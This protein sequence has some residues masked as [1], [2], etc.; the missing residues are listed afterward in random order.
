ME[1]VVVMTFG[2]EAFSN[3]LILELYSQGNIILTDQNYRIIQC[4][5]SHQFTEKVRT[6]VGELYP[7]EYAAN[8]YL[9]K[10]EV[11]EGRVREVLKEA[12]NPVKE[13][14]VKEEVKENKKAGKGKKAE[15]IEYF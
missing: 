5:R 15:S 9:E 2:A 11:E 7:F 1:R 3:H 14:E 6:A 10:I 12:E 13:E 8:I 4:M